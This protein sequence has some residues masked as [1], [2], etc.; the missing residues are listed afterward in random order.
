MLASEEFDWIVRLPVVFVPIVR[1]GVIV[2]GLRLFTISVTEDIVVDVEPSYPEF[3][4]ILFWML[5]KPSIA[6]LIT[7][8]YVNGVSAIIPPNH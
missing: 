8:L 3:V 7:V 2:A 6:F 1:V 5:L 4:Y